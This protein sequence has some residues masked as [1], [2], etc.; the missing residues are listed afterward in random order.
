MVVDELALRPVAEDIGRAASDGQ[1]VEQHPTAARRVADPGDRIK[2]T[3]LRLRRVLPFYVPKP[4]DLLVQIWER[5][6]ALT[7]GEPTADAALPD[8]ERVE[9]AGLDYEEAEP[10]AVVPSRVGSSRR[11]AAA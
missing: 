9:D 10:M 5:Q 3:N 4:K 11:K 6:R 7:A 2:T 1:L 8:D